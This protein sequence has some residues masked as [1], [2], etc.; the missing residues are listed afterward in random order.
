[1]KNLSILINKKE[2]EQNNHN[3][4]VFDMKEINKNKDELFGHLELL[5]EYVFLKEE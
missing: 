5:L 4:K 2:I 3:L 1:V